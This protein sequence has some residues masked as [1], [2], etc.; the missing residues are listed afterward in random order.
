MREQ[1]AWLIYLFVH[2][3]AILVANVL[4][5]LLLW[6]ALP[7]LVIYIIFGS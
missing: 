1:L 5:L 4:G 2:Y 3:F 7:V 6:T